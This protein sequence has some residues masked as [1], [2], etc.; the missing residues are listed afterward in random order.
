[1]G[2]L[3]RLPN[4]FAQYTLSALVASSLVKVNRLQMR[5]NPAVKVNRLH[6]RGNLAAKKGVAERCI[7]YLCFAAVSHDRLFEKL[8]WVHL[9]AQATVL[10]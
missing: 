1:M 10:G 6:M 9:W 8:H 2:G 4:W 7:T 5:G 3:N